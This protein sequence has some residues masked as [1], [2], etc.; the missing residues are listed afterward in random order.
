M[1][2]KPLDQILAD[3]RRVAARA[4]RREDDLRDL[5]ELLRTR[6]S[7]RRTA[8]SPRPRARRP[9][10]VFVNDVGLL[11][12]LLQHE[13]GVVAELDVVGLPVDAVDPGR[14]RALFA[15]ADLEVVGGEPYDL[16][17]VQDRRRA[18]VGA[19]AKGS[20]ARNSSPS[21]SADDERAAEPGADDLAGALRAD[22]RQAV[23]PF[24]MWQRALDGLRT[25]RRPSPSSLRDQVGDD[26]GVGLAAEA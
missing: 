22:D 25:G 3:E 18:G 14:D 13:V 12:D 2:A 16:A 15:M 8:P 19:I 4:A 20:L 24:Q 1:R 9:R 6:G 17:V 21:P 7:A 26:L 11:V 5:A 10:Q 23:R